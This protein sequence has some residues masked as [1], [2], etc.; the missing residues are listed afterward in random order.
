MWSGVPGIIL[1]MGWVYESRRYNVTAPL[2]GHTQIDRWCSAGISCMVIPAQ[3]IDA[4]SK[5]FDE[6]TFDF[7]I[8]GN[9][10][11]AHPR[12]KILQSPILVTPM[13]PFTNMV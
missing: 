2:I 12:D 6:K 7:M 3:T 4:V 10:A 11:V 1:G 9:T 13:A 5:T 8:N